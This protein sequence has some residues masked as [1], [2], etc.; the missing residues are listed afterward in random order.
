METYTFT[1]LSANTETNS[2]LIKYTPDNI[3]LSEITQNISAE[4]EDFLQSI[5]YCAPQTSWENEL[6]ALN[7]EPHVLEIGN[8]IGRSGTMTLDKILEVKSTYYQIYKSK[9]LDNQNMEDI[10]NQFIDELS[11]F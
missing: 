11:Q 3:I 10:K 7:G 8:Y 9:G 2:V 1:I 6:N 5:D 4:T